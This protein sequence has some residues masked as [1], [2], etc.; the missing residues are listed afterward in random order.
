[1]IL[2][3]GV[4]EFANV[5]VYPLILLKHNGLLCH[6]QTTCVFELASCQW[7]PATAHRV[8]IL[9]VMYVI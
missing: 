9:T 5:I 4:I 2:L 7:G 6:V 1:M 3:P 8:V